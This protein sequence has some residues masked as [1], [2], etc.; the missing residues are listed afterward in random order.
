MTALGNV[1][2][3]SFSLSP[4]VFVP[5]G[6]SRTIRSEDW[7]CLCEYTHHTLFSELAK[8]SVNTCCSF[9]FKTESIDKMLMIFK[10][11]ILVCPCKQKCSFLGRHTIS[12]SQHSSETFQTVLLTIQK[13]ISSSPESLKRVKM[14]YWLLNWHGYIPRDLEEIIPLG[15]CTLRNY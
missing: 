14:D 9:N 13:Q 11:K 2:I 5:L 15:M 7:E 8:I 12:H 1:W 6:P 4:S 10:Q 3:S